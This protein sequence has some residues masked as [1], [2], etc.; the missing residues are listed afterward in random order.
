[1]TNL[2]LPGQY[3]ER[4]LGPLGLQGPYYHWNRWYLPGVGRYLEPDP[5]ALAGYFNTP[6]GVDWYGYAF[7]NPLRY[8]DPTGLTP[9]PDWL[10]DLVRKKLVAEWLKKL[11]KPDVAG[12][13]ALVCADRACR[14]GHPREYFEAFGD[15][16]TIIGNEFRLPTGDPYDST[17]F[18]GPCAKQCEAL[19]HSSEF[20]KNCEGVACQ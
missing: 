13:G 20:K 17:A 12:L 3:D 8:T 6:H 2:R 10:M 7:Q 18:A 9:A 11:M 1:V 4:L 19:T 16:V 5:L 15:C 14:N